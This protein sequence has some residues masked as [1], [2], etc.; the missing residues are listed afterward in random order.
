MRSL[1]ALITNRSIMASHYDLTVSSC[2]QLSRHMRR[3]KLQGED[4]SSFPRDQA[5]G[6]VK[7][8]L[9]DENGRRVK[10]SYTIREFDGDTLT[11][12]FADH[13]PLGPA[14]RWAQS[15]LPGS[16]IRVFGP[17]EKKLADPN[18]DWFF[19]GG[20]ISSLP[21]ISVNLEALK[22]SAVGY[23][24]IS[25]PHESDKQ[26][27]VHPAG[28]QL[29]WVIDSAITKPTLALTEKIRSLEWLEGVPYPWFAGEFE[30]M[31][32]MRRFFRDEMKIDRKNMYLSC[33]WKTGTSDEGMKRAKFLDAEEDL[34]KF[35]VATPKLGI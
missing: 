10:R 19:F 15:A 11:L 20:D 12:D 5:S 1:G 31:R 25:V 24:V 9:E 13:Q 27:L 22:A 28:V 2:S 6:Y 14:S 21:A 8:S 17:G 23:A 26:F 29:I 34:K 4:L 3:I 35:D 30:G 16:V 32:D 33:Y 18:A 7:L